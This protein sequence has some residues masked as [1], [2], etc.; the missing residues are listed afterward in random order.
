MKEK[1]YQLEVL[2]VLSCINVILIHVCNL[3]SRSFGQISDG[4]Y[5]FSV[6]LNAYARTSVPIF[7]MISGATCL[8]RCYDF[9]KYKKR[10]INTA[11]VLVIASVL[12]RI[13]NILYFDRAYDY[14]DLFD[15]PTKL[16]L[17]YMY[18]YLGILIMLPFLQNM[19][20]NLDRKFE[21]LFVVI[22]FVFIVAYRVLDRLNMDIG[23][24]LPIIGSTYYIGYFVLG[25]L[26]CK[27]LKEIKIKRFWLYVIRYGSLLTTVLFM[28]YGSF[29]R[30]KHYDWY[31][32]YRA[33]FIAVASIALFILV[34]SGKAKKCMFFGKD[35]VT[36][37][38]RLSF[39]IYLIHP[40]FL[41]LIKTELDYAKWSPYVAIP[42]GSV[43]TFICAY[44][45]AAL[46]AFIKGALKK[47]KKKDEK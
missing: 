9:N 10:V 17:W 27:Y 40:F 47:V 1:N 6:V 32:Q 46:I 4:E 14:H 29:S 31:W 21:M 22:W 36:S 11:V 39:T 20:Q 33:L 15:T 35:A 8:G 2:R 42:A 7:F 43:L 34:A 5:V 45:S 41:D 38:A 44:A 37:I 19:L 24:P 12:Y 28:C 25:Y 13:W 26:I 30:G 18:A 16:H 3:Y 23:Y